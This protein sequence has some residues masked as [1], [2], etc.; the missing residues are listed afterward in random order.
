M[1]FDSKG[2]VN[3][4]IALDTAIKGYENELQAFASQ[5]LKKEVVGSEQGVVPVRLT[6]AM[7]GDAKGDVKFANGSSI[8]SGDMEI[9]YVQFECERYGRQYSIDV[10]D[11][12]ELSERDILKA[13]DFVKSAASHGHGGLDRELGNILRGGGSA[14]KF[15]LITMEALA[16]G[17]EFNNYD[18]ATSNPMGAIL[19]LVTDTLGGN[20]LFLGRDVAN[21]LRQHPQFTGDLGTSR[22][23]AGK[24]LTYDAFAE[25][26]MATFGL[27]AVNIDG[28]YYQNGGATQ[29]LSP[30]QPLAGVCAVSH[31]DNIVLVERK[32]MSPTAWESPETTS[33]NVASWGSF[34]IIVGDKALTKGF[35]NTLE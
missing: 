26:L 32:A 23:A 13:E 17:A 15:D 6:A 10:L 35:S 3:V 31:F 18:S 12:Q 9:A 16:S 7:I 30:L 29:K 27:Q 2:L 1:S 19:D 5:K 33:T 4:K 25:I 28:T 11:A 21:A 24:M 34:D 22:T 14:A 20:V 8:P